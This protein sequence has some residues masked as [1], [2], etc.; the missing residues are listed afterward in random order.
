MNFLDLE[1]YRFSRAVKTPKIVS[2]T[3]CDNTS[4]PEIV[5]G[6]EAIREKFIQLIQ[7]STVWHNGA[8]YDLSCLLNENPD[9]WLVV[10]RAIEEGRV[11]DTLIREKLHKIA[12]GK[13][14]KGVSQD[15]LGK[16]Y[17]CPWRADKSE[18]G[19][20]L[21]FSELDGIPVSDWPPEPKEYAINDVKVLRWN[22][23]AQHQSTPS[24]YLRQQFHQV[25]HGIMLR[26]I[27]KAGFRVDRG[28]LQEIE[29]KLSTD[30]SVL[31]TELMRAGL[32]YERKKDRKI[33]FHLKKIR[34]RF[35]ALC[36]EK[37]W[38]VP[39]TE[40]S[41]EA[42]IGTVELRNCGDPTLELY[43]RYRDMSY[44]RTVATNLINASDEDERIHT[45]FDS[46]K[47][48]GRSSSYDPAMQ[49]LPKTYGIRE[50]FLPDE[51]NVLID[52][53]FTSLEFCMFAQVCKD[54]LGYSTIADAMNAG[55][56][57]HAM[58]AA[59]L[60]G[61]TYEEAVARKNEPEGERARDMGKI[62]N[63]GFLGG[64]GP[65]RACYWALKKSDKMRFT[66]AQMKELKSVWLRT[67][68]ETREFFTRVKTLLEN[69]LEQI[70]VERTGFVRGGCRYTVGCN[71]FFQHL[72][73]MVSKQAGWNIL[74]EQHTPGSALWGSKTVAYV[75]DQYTLSVPESKC[76]EA[77]LVVQ[78][79]MEDA[80]R[81]WSP[82]C[83][84]TAQPV[85]MRRWSKKA[86]R[87]IV[88]GR[89]V[90]WE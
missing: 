48:T 22:F 82:D 13:P 43:L 62:A 34:T 19:W 89:L 87:V 67:W 52:A 59:N 37:G 68:P 51:G 79:C 32:C 15:S 53:D 65:E 44:A 81:Q 24:G 39:R 29:H 9:L 26:E 2:L 38:P 42:K 17:K 6:S 10:I 30:L 40:K 12:T 84:S 7:G 35:E 75:H 69:P 23:F 54:L 11:Y 45:S 20:R 74:K 66:I 47:Q 14:T 63:Y 86:K 73:S 41:G 78:R 4:E 31:E 27:S 83:V 18:D 28:R 88:D 57:P 25:A 8:G 1:T 21:R 76:H 5:T 46:L 55:K 71:T 72:G 56:D 90:P 70:T 36:Q 50:C 49:N 85:A 33:C 58:V 60:K 3:W 77:A 61:W 80:S 16:L 64:L